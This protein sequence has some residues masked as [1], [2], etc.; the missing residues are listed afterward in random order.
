MHNLGKTNLESKAVVFQK[1]CVNTRSHHQAVFSRHSWS[2]GSFAPSWTVVVH[3]RSTHDSIPCIHTKSS[4]QRHR[5]T[6]AVGKIWLHPS[7]AKH[8]I[9]QMLSSRQ[10]WFQLFCFF[11]KGITSWSDWFKHITRADRTAPTK[12][13]HCLYVR[14]RLVCGQVWKRLGMITERSRQLTS[15]FHRGTK[16][17]WWVFARTL[18]LEFE[19]RIRGGIVKFSVR[20]LNGCIGWFDRLAVSYWLCARE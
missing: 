13:S 5:Q 15:H 19:G 11:T 18:F 16:K 2:T 1:A 12:M 7:M 10:G 20:I 6:A 9:W 3:S 17:G 8:R 14:V 4:V